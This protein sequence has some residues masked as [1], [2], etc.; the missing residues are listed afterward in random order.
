VTHLSEQTTESG[1]CERVACELYHLW[2]DS[3]SLLCSAP[4]DEPTSIT[5][6][7]HWKSIQHFA[8]TPPP[9]VLPECKC[10]FARSVPRLL[11]ILIARF[12]PKH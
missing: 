2:K 11:L 5:R 4:I 10:A 9:F 8:D 6:S 3:C 1:S 12:T 7:Q